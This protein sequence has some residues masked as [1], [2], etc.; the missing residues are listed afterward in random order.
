MSNDGNDLDVTVRF[1]DNT[2]AELYYDLKSAEFN[3]TGPLKLVRKY[4]ANEIRTEL[5][6]VTTSVITFLFYARFFIIYFVKCNL[7]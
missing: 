6:N 7:S 5:R 2:G 3:I 1:L 4:D